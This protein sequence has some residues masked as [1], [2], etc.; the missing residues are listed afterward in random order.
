M[1][2]VSMLFGTHNK[3]NNK[4]LNKLSRAEEFLVKDVSY[5]EENV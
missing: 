4:H 2:A 5:S 1:V 3:S